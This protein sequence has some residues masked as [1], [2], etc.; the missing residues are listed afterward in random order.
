MRL[1]ERHLKKIVHEEINK[2]LQEG[3]F[4][5]VEIALTAPEGA[6]YELERVTR[7]YTLHEAFHHL[8]EWAENNGYTVELTGEGTSIWDYTFSKDG[9]EQFVTVLHGR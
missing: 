2:V 5:E 9:S 1:T 7:G 8:R 3:S 6:D 4:S